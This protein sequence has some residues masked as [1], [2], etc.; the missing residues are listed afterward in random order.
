MNRPTLPSSA[1]MLVTLITEEI[2]PTSRSRSSSNWF[3]GWPVPLVAAIWA[4]RFATCPAIVFRLATE[5]FTSCVTPACSVLS[6]SPAARTRND[7]SCAWPSTTWRADESLGL[8][9]T[10]TNALSRLPAAAPMP[11][12][13]I[14]N[15]SSSWLSLSSRAASAAAFEPLATAWWVRKLSYERAIVVTVTPLP[16]K[17]TPVNWPGESASWAV[18]REYPGVFALA[19]LL[20][21]VC[22]AA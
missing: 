9:E 11:C 18:W 15:T 22:S 7:S 16:K 4:F 5:A 17:P 14:G 20:L 3:G 10:S 21:A 1:W 13:P 2:W 12:L 19:M 8:F 6:W